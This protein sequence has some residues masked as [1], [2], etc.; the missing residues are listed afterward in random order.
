MWGLRSG[1]GMI[2]RGLHLA[3]GPRGEATLH[4]RYHSVLR[5]LDRFDPPEDEETLALLRLLSARANTILDVGANTGRYAYLFARSARP[6][7]VIHAFEPFP[8]AAALLRSNVGRDP[9]VR[10]HP[11][12]LG[13]VDEAAELTIPVDWMGN[14]ISALAYLSDQQGHPTN[15][16]SLRVEVRRL[17]SL[18]RTGT[19]ELVPPV[20]AKI[21][22]E[23]SESAVLAGATTLLEARSSLYFEFEAQHVL[24]T[25]GSSP[26]SLLERARY[27]VLTR[28]GLGWRIAVQPDPDAVNYLGIPLER[29]PAGLTDAGPGSMI[30][31]S[32]L[33]A[34]LAGWV[35]S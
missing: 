6:H 12:A 27:A 26:W 5:R 14:P 20:L 13:S 7:V 11:M 30:P 25:G 3:L 21:D 35:P 10:I 23:G 17:D 18:V 31:D 24:R 16:G 32:E 33:V 9:R 4:R 28:S 34:S 1:R 22:V 15:A 19:V 2:R 29:L 8:A